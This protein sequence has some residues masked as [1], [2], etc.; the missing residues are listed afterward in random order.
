M[1]RPVRSLIPTLASFATDRRGAVA[2]TSAIL[3]TTLIGF[4]ALGVDVG[5]VYTDRRKAQGVVDLAALSAVSDLANAD[6]AA[7]ATIARNKIADAAYRLEYGTY[8]ANLAVP[9]DKRFVPSDQAS[10]NAARVTLSSSTPLFF[11]RILT[12][13]DKFA[14]R[15]TAT[16]TQSSFAQFAIGSRLLKIDGGLLNAM[17][18]SMLGTT[19]SLSVMDYDAL[20]SMKLDAFGVVNA[21]ATRMQIT[22]G[23]YD[24]VLNASVTSGDFFGAMVDTAKQQYGALDRGVLAL[25]AIWQRA[26]GSSSKIKVIS[27]IDLGPYATMSVGQKPKVSASLAAFDM[28]SAVAGLAT[29]DNQ[30]AFAVNAGIPGIA[31]ASLKVAIGERPQGTSWVAFGSTGATVHTAQT[32]ILLNVQLVGVAPYAAVNVP[33][34][35]EIASGTATLSRLSCGFPDI[36]ASRVT[37]DVT[38]GLIDAWIGNVSASQFINFSSAPNPGPAALVDVAGLKVTGKA[39][40]SVSNMSPT[41]VTFTYSD[42]VAYRKQTVGTSSFSGS[43][44]ASLLGNTQL[45]VSV[46]GLGLGVPAITAG[47]S[48]LLV[49]AASPI[50]QLLSSVLQTLGVGLGQADVW[51]SNLRCDG[52][53]LVI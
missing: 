5:S 53:V 22:A 44:L 24:K 2:V 9:P 12:G 3:L 6:K 23:T 39:H 17:L 19:L 49:N 27:M 7:G 32:R 29:G 45:G 15:T 28:V 33:I 43:L 35:I 36:A 30:A 31:S 41:P 37:L 21:L 13:Q 10:A 8:S 25:T 26:L 14:V 47:V 20:L 48:G 52:A 46:L 18:G 1:K 16:A 38:P 34:Y 42:I 51:V 50:D 11:A 4:T 40:V